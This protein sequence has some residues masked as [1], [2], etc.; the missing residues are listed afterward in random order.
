ERT[1]YSWVEFGRVD[2][3]GVERFVTLG[4]GV[5]AV[6]HRGVVRQWWFVT[7]QRVGEDLHLVD[8]LRTVRTRERLVEAIGDRGTVFDT[9]ERY[10]RAVD[11]ALFG[12]HARYD[13]L[14]D[15]LVQLRQP[16]LSKRPNEQHLNDALT[17]ALPPVRDALVDVVAQSYQSLEEEERDLTRL[18]AGS[19]AVR[20]FT[21]EYTRYARDAT[22]RASLAPRRAQSDY[23]ERRRLLRAGEEGLGEAAARHE[24]AGRAVAAD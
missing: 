23:E 15:L 24:S 10:R 4:L 11:E 20:A 1:G 14:V 16:Q 5:K 22:A 12:L 3:E 21:T 7:D 9:A 18:R 17:E 13:A 19:D 2:E 8:R 6:Q